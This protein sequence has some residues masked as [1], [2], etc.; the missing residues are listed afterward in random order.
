[1]SYNVLHGKCIKSFFLFHSSGWAFDHNI[2]ILNSHYKNYILNPLK[3]CWEISWIFMGKNIFQ[4]LGFVLHLFRNLRSCL[5]KL[6]THK[7]ELQDI[8]QYWKNHTLL[9]FWVTQTKCSLFLSCL[10]FMFRVFMGFTGIFI[11]VTRN[12]G[13]FFIQKGWRFYDLF[14]C[15]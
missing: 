12:F 3:N 14:L 9:T 5:E 1:M 10:N 13:T 15:S 11:K 4:V 8:T 6:K 2:E 7:T